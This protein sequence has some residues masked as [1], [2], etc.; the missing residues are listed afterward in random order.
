MTKWGKKC[1]WAC[2]YESK[3]LFEY[4]WGVFSAV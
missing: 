2:N 1:S 3:T 4:V